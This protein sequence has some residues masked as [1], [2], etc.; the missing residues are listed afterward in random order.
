MHFKVKKDQE[1]NQFYIDWEDLKDMFDS[2]D[3][4]NSYKLEWLEDGSVAMEFFDIDGNKVLV[5]NEKK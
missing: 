5:R 1:T 2:P 4:V 3:L